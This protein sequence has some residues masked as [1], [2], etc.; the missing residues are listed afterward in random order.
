[1][2]FPLFLF[3]LAFYT[4]KKDVIKRNDNIVRKWEGSYA[5]GEDRRQIHPGM[6]AEQQ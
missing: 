3:Q 6:E 5:G 1:M 2:W 4:D